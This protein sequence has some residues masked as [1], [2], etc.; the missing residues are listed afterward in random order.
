MMQHPL[1]L[2]WLGA[3]TL[4]SHRNH[5][6]LKKHPFSPEFVE[7]VNLRI[8]KHRHEM[9]GHFWP[10]RLRSLTPLI[11]TECKRQ[12]VYFSV[13]TMWVLAI[14]P[15]FI[16][17]ITQ[18]THHFSCHLSQCSSKHATIN[19][20]RGESQGHWWRVVFCSISTINSK[21]WLA[22]KVGEYFLAD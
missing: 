12:G 10:C 19:Q 3:S 8:S 22:E 1:P 9:H 5:F 17:K 14:S 21:N 4:R 13:K 16:Q 6:L 20:K 11:L 15:M 2:S 18:N 7:C